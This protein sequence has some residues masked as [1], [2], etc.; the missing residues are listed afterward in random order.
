[1]KAGMMTEKEMRQIFQKQLNVVKSN[2][3]CMICNIL[4]GSQEGHVKIGLDKAAHN[5]CYYLSFKREINK[6]I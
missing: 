2:G 6:N 4:I 5:E 1:M 3:Y